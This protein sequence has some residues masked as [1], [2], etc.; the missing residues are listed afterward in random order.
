MEMPG[1]TFRF[2]HVQL[3]IFLTLMLRDSFDPLPQPFRPN[4]KRCEDISDQSEG[5][6][7]VTAESIKI[8]PVARLR[9]QRRHNVA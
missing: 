1:A 2:L 6:D 7:H 5:V 4:A 8:P 3:Q 9:H